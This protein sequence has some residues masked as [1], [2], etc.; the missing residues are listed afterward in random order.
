MRVE[1]FLYL[2]KVYQY[3]CCLMGAMLWKKEYSN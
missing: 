1:F 2:C 3:L